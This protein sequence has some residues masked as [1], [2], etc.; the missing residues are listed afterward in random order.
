MI[1]YGAYPHIGKMVG[2]VLRMLQLLP[3]LSLKIKKK[4]WVTLFRKRKR[5]LKN[6]FKINKNA[7]GRAWIKLRFHHSMC[8][9]LNL[10]WVLWIVVFSKLVSFGSLWKTSCPHSKIYNFWNSEDPHILTHDSTALVKMDYFYLLTMVHYMKQQCYV[11]CIPL[12]IVD[13]LSW[14]SGALNLQEW[15]R[16]PRSRSFYFFELKY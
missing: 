16:F 2:K 13:H 6:H 12:V 3:H 8:Y 7:C 10:C 5:G 14:A 11:S 1:L 15:S 4:N 9:I